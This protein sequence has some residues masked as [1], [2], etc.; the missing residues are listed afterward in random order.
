VRYRVDF[1]GRFAIFVEPAY[2]G[3]AGVQTSDLQFKTQVPMGSITEYVQ[4][5]KD[6]RCCRQVIVQDQEDD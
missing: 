4:R 5:L 2:R 6:E 1:L 3:G